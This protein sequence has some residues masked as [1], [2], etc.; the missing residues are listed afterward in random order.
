LFSGYG[1]ILL[2]QVLLCM[3]VCS[4]SGLVIG[5]A[6]GEFKSFIKAMFNENNEIAYFL[7]SEAAGRRGLGQFSPMVDIKT[8][9]GG[10]R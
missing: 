8:R 4:H 5:H 10:L 1:L 9:R 7:M 2:Q 3:P 6:A